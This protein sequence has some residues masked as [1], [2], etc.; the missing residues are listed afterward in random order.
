MDG[1]IVPIEVNSDV[2]HSELLR[3]SQCGLVLNFLGRLVSAQN[4]PNWVYA[5]LCR[6][7]IFTQCYVLGNGI[8]LATC[9]KQQDAYEPLVRGASCGAWLFTF[10]IPWSPHFDT[11]P[12]HIR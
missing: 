4:I 5:V 12:D 7:D 1:C 6:Q 11:T 8:Y 3:L 9:Q 10:V 2:L